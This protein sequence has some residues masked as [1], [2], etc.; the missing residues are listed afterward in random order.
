M[1][2]FVCLMMFTQPSHATEML[3]DSLDTDD[4]L[5]II[6]GSDTLALKK[7]YVLDFPL[8][9]AEN[10]S[11][12]KEKSTQ[13]KPRGEATEKGLAATGSI[14]RGIQVSSNASVSLQSSMYLKISGALSENY[15]VSGVL[16][17]KTSPLQPIGNTRRL[18]DFDRVYIGI[19][20][21]QL[22]AAIGDIDLKLSNGKYGK[23]DRSIEGITVAAQHSHYGANAALGFSYGNYHLLQMQ[24]KDGKQGPYRLTGKNGEKF[25]I[26]LAGSEQVKVDDRTLERGED[27]DYIIDYNAAEIHFTQNKILS[28]NSRISIEFEYVPDIYLA[29]YSFGKQLMSAG[30]SYGDQ[31]GSPFFVSVAFRDLRDDRNNPLGNINSSDL[32]AIFSPLPTSTDTVHQNSIIVDSINGSY[33]MDPQGFLVYTGVALG[34]Y[35]AQFNYVGLERGQYRRELDRDGNF[36]VFDLVNGEYL[37][38]NQYFAPRALSI[39]SLS[40]GFNSKYIDAALDLGVSQ[41][42]NNTY[43]SEPES[44]NKIAWDGSVGTKAQSFEIK[45][46]DKYYESGFV[47]HDVL[48]SVEYYRK[49]QISPRI[50]EE[51]DLKYGVIRIGE[52]NKSYIKTS[53][54]QFTRS[55][56]VIGEQFQVETKTNTD[57]ALSLGYNSVIT[58]MDTSLSQTHNFQSK[59]NTGRLSTDLR[60]DVEVGNTSD[61]YPVNDHV[62]AGIGLN[63]KVNQTDLIEVNYD[64]RQD[65]RQTNQDHSVLSTSNLH[66]WSDRR[67]DWSGEYQFKDLLN[68]SGKLSGKYREHQADTNAATTYYLGNLQ[69]TGKMLNDRVRFQEN[70]T[71]DE[72][73]IPRYDYHYL[74]VD[75]GYGDFSYDPYISDYIPV[76]GGRFI[77]QR[78]FSDVEEQVRKRE[79]KTRI[80]YSSRDYGKK[81]IQGV[82]GRLAYDSRLKLQVESDAVIQNQ[83]SI[84]FKMD[85]LTGREFMLKKI[86]YSGKSTD[87]QSTLYNYGNEDNSFLSHGFDSEFSWN[88]QNLSK[89]GML[90]EK[91]VRD[92]EYNPL[93]TESWVSLRPSLVHTLTLS[94]FQKIIMQLK[95]S[96]VEDRHLDLQYAEQLVELDHKLRIKKRGRVDQR[97]TLSN[98]DADAAGIPYS[99][100]NGRQPGQNWKYTINSRYTFSSMFQISVNYSLQ[101]RGENRSEQYLRVEGRT[102]F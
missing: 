19:D 16:T 92:V 81:N 64:Q 62:N 34:E 3:R 15:R 71:I 38:T 10:D 85:Y 52:L 41:E 95:Y 82:K 67:Q 75:T 72:E 57:K 88:N 7:I 97:L 49:W 46:G 26:V 98:I 20:G 54:A 33:S 42:V 45:V 39:L 58:Q 53:G 14:S 87:N 31:A 99:V 90:F 76:T 5:K 56:E 23:L 4:S 28:S 37:P 25:I 84:S 55:D 70:Y 13:E 50:A 78:I 66:Q 80:E 43:S 100:F 40:S 77:R 91:R 83:S 35:S 94:P 12:A 96:S 22:N 32:E 89:I 69:F 47:S 73:H 59:L 2:F 68:T 21:P 1:V 86:V 93:A 101:E 102:H 44:V 48:E 79:N 61:Y 63:Y 29:S 9:I 18:N 24:G 65:Y 36:Y 6:V 60:V 27:A 51:E 11:S 74:E 8:Y 17:D 30:V